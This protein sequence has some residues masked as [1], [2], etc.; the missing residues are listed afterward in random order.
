MI[1]QIA[2]LCDPQFLRTRPLHAERVVVRE[3]ERLRH[4]DAEFRQLRSQGLR[5]ANSLAREDLL[6]E[7]ASVFRIDVERV[8]E[9]GVPD[10]AS[11]AEAGFH[12]DWLPGIANE[13]GDGLRE[14][15]G[16]GV[17]LGAD[18]DLKEAVR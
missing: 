18:A 6:V 3:A 7:C 16:F 17:G 14:D 9:Q 8:C 15:R 1:A 4:A 10:K 5:R 2:D 11:A 12:F 13:M